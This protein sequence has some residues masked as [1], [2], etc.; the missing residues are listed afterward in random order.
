MK[1]SF[2]RM[3]RAIMVASIHSL[4][5]VSGGKVLLS[6][7]GPSIPSICPQP[8]KAGEL[9]AFFIVALSGLETFA[10]HPAAS[11]WP[12][13]CWFTWILSRAVHPRRPS[14]Q[15]TGSSGWGICSPGG[16]LDLIS[17]DITADIRPSFRFTVTTHTL[18]CACECTLFGR[19]IR[20]PAV[21]GGFI[22]YPLRVPNHPI[23]KELTDLPLYRTLESSTMEKRHQK[24]S[25]FSFIIRSV[26]A[27]TYMS[28]M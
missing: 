4:G 27:I 11:A 23:F 9:T 16:R 6:L 21:A 19:P 25:V 22:T 18:C 7:F 1:I 10:P 2:H 5:R 24:D 28:Y 26:M 13:M 14:Y 8:Y 12:G 15:R 3:N 20:R 17:V